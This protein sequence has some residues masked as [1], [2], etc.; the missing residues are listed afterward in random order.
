VEDE[1][2]HKPPVWTFLINRIF[3]TVMRHHQ[4]WCSAKQNVSL[5]T[6]IR[7]RLF[8]QIL[9]QAVLCQNALPDSYLVFCQIPSNFQKPY[10]A[11]AEQA[12]NCPEGS[13]KAVRTSSVDAQSISFFTGDKENSS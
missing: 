1:L 13:L 9:K 3:I 10:C 5:H 11:N 2:L 4:R 8:P 7:P 12:M 6:F